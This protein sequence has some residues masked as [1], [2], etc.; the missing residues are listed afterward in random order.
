M[1]VM[2]EERPRSQRLAVGQQGGEALSVNPFDVG[3]AGQLGDGRDEVGG[4]GGRGLDA[5]LDG[6]GPSDDQRD[7]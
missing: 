6:A 2:P 4:P 5:G 3:K 1:R 7:A